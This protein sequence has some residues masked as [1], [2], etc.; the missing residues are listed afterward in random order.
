MS[1]FL[2]VTSPF[3]V[4][5]YTARI[6]ILQLYMHKSQTTQTYTWS[7]GTSFGLK[8]PNEL[9]H[10]FR[11][12][13]Q[14]YSDRLQFIMT[15]EKYVSLFAIGVSVVAQFILG[16]AFVTV[17]ILSLFALEEHQWGY[18]LGWISTG[19]SATVIAMSSPNN[20]SIYGT[21]KIKKTK[22]KIEVQFG[23]PFKMLTQYYRPH[24]VNMIYE[25]LGV[26]ATPYILFFKVLPRLPEIR[27][28]IELRT[29]GRIP[30]II[31]PQSNN[32]GN[33]YLSDIPDDCFDSL[34]ETD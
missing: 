7:T 26:L 9:H 23:V 15:R 4:V 11:K 1:I 24:Y 13:L 19:I 5:Y 27:K 3:F 20:S 14:R 6:A 31:Y 32:N 10:V 30:S 25:V 28:V 22:R 8:R 12:R 18:S 29:H 16:C 21:D 2:L 33:S 34:S 17:F